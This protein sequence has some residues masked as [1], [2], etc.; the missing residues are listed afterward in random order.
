MANY[1][2]IA[3]PEGFNFGKP[4]EW[5]IWFKRFQR[6]RIASGLSEKSENEQ[7]NALVYI[8]GD[9]AEEI[10][11]LFNLSEAQNNDYKL[12]VSKF[13]N[14]FIGKRNVI[15]ERA[16][17]N[18]RSQGESE[19]V[20]EFITNLYVLAE[21]CNYGI[22][23]EEMIRDRLV[24][25]VKNFNLS[26]KLQLESELTLEKA[27]QIVRQS[28]S[29]KNQQKEIRQDTENRD[30]HQGWSS[31]EKR[32]CFR[33]GYYQGHSK[34]RCPAKDAI[35]N[36][37]RK[38]GH[39]AKVCH[40]KT[41]QEVSSSQ[42]NAFIG[43][44]GKQENVEDKWCEVIK[45]NDQPIKFK[46]D[47]GAEVLVMPEEIYLQHFGYLKT[48]KADKNLFAVS[49]KIEVNG[50]FQAFLESKR[51]KCEESIYI[52]KGVARPL[53]SC[54]AS[55]IL[56]LV[57]RIN[58]VEDHAP[59]KLDPML[60]FPKLFTGLGKIDIP[61]KIKLKEG[62][63]PY[64]IYTP[65]RVPIPLMKELQM[66]LERM[67]SNGVIE[68]VEG[69]S[70]WCSPMVLV[71]KPSGKLRI[72]VDFSILNQNIQREIHPIP[73]VEHTL[74]QLKGAKLFTKLDANSG[75][76]QIPLSS[77]SS[78]LTTFI[79]PFGRFRF[80]R[81]PFGLEG[82]LCHMDDI[83][84]YGS[85]QEEHDKRLE[86]VLTRLS[87]LGLT[88]N[89]DK[90]KF[91]ATTI[92]FLGHQIDP[93]GI[94][95]DP[96]RKRAILQF[97]KP[98]SVKELKQFLGMKEEWIWEDDQDR[99]F[100]QIKKNLTSAQGL[101]LY[102]PS[103][104]I[105]VSADASSFGLGAVIW[106]TK[107]GLRQVIAYAS[108][109]LSKTEK[110]YAQIEKEALAIT[111]ACEKFKQY[112]QGL[113]ITLETEHKPLI[114][115]TPGKNLIVADALSRSPRMK[116]GTQELEE[117]LCA[118]VQQVVSFMPISDVRVKEIKESQDKDQ[119]I[120]NIIKYTQEGW[121]ERTNVSMS[122]SQYWPAKDDFS[123]ESGILL[124]GSRYYC[125]STSNRPEIHVTYNPPNGYTAE[126][127]TP[128]TLRGRT[129][130]PALERAMVT[131]AHQDNVLQPIN[132]MS[133]TS[134]LQPHHMV[135][136]SVGP[137]PQA[138]NI[139]IGYGE[140]PCF[141]PEEEEIEDYVEEFKM[142]LTASKVPKGDWTKAL[143]RRLPLDGREFIK[144]RF[145]PSAALEDVLEA[146]KL[147][148]P[149]NDG[150][151]RSR[152]NVLKK[153]R[154][155][156]STEDTGKYLMNLI[157]AHATAGEFSPFD[158][159]KEALW[160]LAP[161]DCLLLAASWSTTRNPEEADF[162]QAAKFLDEAD[163][164]NKGRKEA[165]TTTSWETTTRTAKKIHAAGRDAKML[166]LLPDGAQTLGLPE[167]EATWFTIIPGNGEKI[168]FGVNILTNNHC[169]IM[170]RDES[171]ELY[172]PKIGTDDHVVELNEERELE[173][174]GLLIPSV[175]VSETV[176]EIFI[177]VINTRNEP[178]RLVAN[179]CLLRSGGEIANVSFLSEQVRYSMTAT[180]KYEPHK[181]DINP[182]LS[183]GE[184]IDVLDVLYRYRELFSEEWNK[185]AD[186]EPY[187]I[188]LKSNT[189]PIRQKAYRR[190][191]KERDIIEEQIKEMCEKGVIRKSTS[192]WA[193]PVVLVKKSDG[194][195]RFCVDYRKVNNVTEKFSYPL[196]NIT[197]C[198]DRLAGMKYF[199]HTDFVSGY[200]QCPLDETSKPITAFT[201]GNGLY[202]FQ[203]LPFGL[204]GAPGHFERIMDTLL[205]ELKWSECMVYLVTSSCLSLKPS[206]C[207]FAYQKL[208]ILGHVVS[209]NGV[210]KCQ[211]DAR[212]EIHT[213]A[214]IVGLGA[215][216]MQ[217]DNDGFLHP[218]HYLSR[219]SSKHESKYGISELECLAIVW[220]LQKLR[221]YI[222][223]REFKV[224]TDHSTLTWL[225][226]VR[227]P[228]SRL[229]RWGLKLM[230]H[231]FEIVH[232]AGRK[233]V[234]PDA[235]SR[236]PFHKNDTNVEDNF[237]DL[238]ACTVRI[239]ENGQK[240][241]TFCRD[242][243]GKLP[244]AK[245]RDEYKKI[246][247]ILYKKNHATQGNQWLVEAPKQSVSE[248]MK[249]AHDIP[250][251]GHMGVAK[252]VHH[253][254]Q[255]FYWKG[256]EED[257][258]KYVRSCKVCQAFK[259][260]R[261]KPAAPL[262]PLPPATDIWERV[263]IDHQGP[264]KKSVEGYEHILTI[265]DRFSEY[266]LAIPVKDTKAETTCNALSDN[267]LYVFGTPKCIICDQ[268]KSFDSSTFRDFTRLYDIKHIMASVAHPQT[269]GLC[270]KL[271]GVIKNGI[272]VY[273]ED[274]H[275]EWPRFVKTATF[276]YNSSIQSSTQVTPHKLIFGV[277][278][279]TSLDVGLPT[280]DE[281]VKTYD[282]YVTNRIL[283][284]ERLKKIADE[285]YRDRTMMTKCQYDLANR[286]RFRK[287]EVG[288]LVL[289]ES[290]RRKPGKTEKF[291]PKYVGLYVITDRIKETTYRLR[292]QDGRNENSRRQSTK[293]LLQ[294]IH[295]GHLGIL[296]CRE[297]AKGSVWW[298]WI[299]SEIEEMVRTC[300]M[301][302]EER[303]NRHQPLL[304]S[305][306][307]NCPWEKVGVDL[308]TIKGQNYLL[309]T[310]YYSRY[311]EI[312]RLEDMTSASVIVHCKSIFARHGIPLEVRSDNGPQFGSLFKEFAQD[313]GFT[314]VTSS[315][316][317]PQSNGFIESFVK[318]VKERI[319][320]SKDPY[321]ALLAYRATP[322]ANGFSPAEL[323]M[324][325][326]IRTAIPT[327]TKQ[328]QPPNL[329]NL[330]NQ[331]AIQREKQKYYFD[332]AK[333]VRELPPLEVND[334]VWLTDLKTPGVIISKEDTPRSYMV[335][336]PRGRVRRNRFHLLPTGQRS[337]GFPHFEPDEEPYINY[338]EANTHTSDAP[339]DVTD[340]ST[341][342]K[343][344]LYRTRSG[345]IVRPPRHFGDD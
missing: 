250:E 251:A 258:R 170:F 259:P 206:K 31:N 223:G 314:H 60:K 2:Q 93:N 82:T 289:L 168:I 316:R 283:E 59:T 198:L 253:I 54:R 20:E 26:E 153:M 306:L 310:D 281:P 202:E 279:R 85:C 295:E 55:E 176:S 39:F 91:A 217:P 189:E 120:Q 320:K 181:L 165:C 138:A 271:N 123:V 312:A 256:L 128:T 231:D 244:D 21:N 212:I 267:L 71:A 98:R 137:A 322:L 41:I 32:K 341:S 132:K 18:R 164:W 273:L 254:K 190:S 166:H 265:V 34:E 311:P 187:H 107:D 264:F 235:L 318:F 241:D 188:K 226:N 156:Q 324:G 185:A 148:Y 116:V 248:I 237:N 276:A 330:K 42:T 305:E 79:T 118:Y 252:T 17:F 113:V 331:E 296:K 297:R 183:D 135:E 72:C 119:V 133:F 344:A 211:A 307:P 225:A 62:A 269:N 37:C 238:T 230:E 144:C 345:R 81:L 219:T 89:K 275:A 199:S 29:V 292:P 22:L 44:V 129:T 49:K 103:L 30:N 240:E 38:K 209:E 255:R 51:Q 112:I 194:S 343:E 337:P 294:R 261:F 177:D 207:R 76:W 67:T 13:Q 161:K 236:N 70:E 46:I 285:N 277:E 40:T 141:N 43:I 334:R 319:G 157:T 290:S 270:E 159:S 4:N 278:P 25:G 288:D 100:D 169:K 69:S 282:E 232:R 338:P 136:S 213:D 56:G 336:T 287:F 155:P 317:Y 315:P 184:K 178:V 286:E 328:H 172:R 339:T 78:A 8:M 126:N 94:Q 150:R 84:V 304:P 99:A 134:P 262:E 301:C 139:S 263:G 173:R 272:R 160:A 152:G 61:Y 245:T 19:P 293:G 333:G 205:A 303:T 340:S 6:Y 83:L 68:K 66:E 242:I 14:Y 12:V 216:L 28:E 325:R 106:Q 7:V 86:T 9:K 215:V 203:V 87:K 321:L 191:P 27:I 146:L 174:T 299:T 291:L 88:L 218:I 201:T 65:R 140:T 192:P 45:V 154:R 208:P 122:E 73:V 16:K 332:R 58:I 228:C 80:K 147:C 57:R 127:R 121:P 96:K 75:F 308:F 33:C 48:E 110:C 64:S 179:S 74:A 143:V 222:F 142:W 280:V 125:V 197:D 221:P 1:M 167:K 10:L 92:K 260:Q 300:P 11:I 109:T 247:G 186:I 193:S 163:R 239:D 102:D 323:S 124:K 220:A 114:V 298:P 326:R 224:V 151:A 249:T 302:I 243:T 104:P 36:K 131:I 149:R 90:C 15:Y 35:C 274:D 117:E 47:T 229:T 210:E 171:V 268:G 246:N 195:Y 257:V 130:N 214:S 284:N 111:W 3:A 234:A 162:L 101:A 77:E 180:C 196:P 342:P 175:H 309:I 24:V 329:K 145:D 53:L 313:Y 233:N 97:P 115:H 227:D 182:E 105:T 63:K 5:P 327:P 50:M 266:A 95:V 200:W 108:R 204:T 158:S 335:D 23:K 52:V